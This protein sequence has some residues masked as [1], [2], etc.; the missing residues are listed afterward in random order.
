MEDIRVLGTLPRYSCASVALPYYTGTTNVASQFIFGVGRL[1]EHTCQESHLSLV[2]QPGSARERM[3]ARYKSLC[4]LAFP[5]FPS[6]LASPLAFLPSA[7]L[8]L[9]EA[10]ASASMA[11]YPY[12][13]TYTA[14]GKTYTYTYN[15]RTPSSTST[16]RFG[17]DDSFDQTIG[18]AIAGYVIA[19]GE[20]PTPRQPSAHM[21][22]VFQLSFSV[23]IFL[24]SLS[25][26]SSTSGGKVEER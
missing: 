25:L 15:V 1:L 18:A 13:T 19:L 9:H 12:T 11:P 22:L 5:R 14:F 4:S 7:H 20:L 10:S 23:F 6:P 8:H 2:G 3:A 16:F 26:L 21:L 24:L 17:G